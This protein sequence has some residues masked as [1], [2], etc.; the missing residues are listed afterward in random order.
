M[1]IYGTYFFV[2]KRVCCFG[3]LTFRMP[4][5]QLNR[6]RGKLVTT[7]GRRDLSFYSANAATSLVLVFISSKAGAAGNQRPLQRLAGKH[8]VVFFVPNASS[9][10]KLTAVQ[11]RLGELDAGNQKPNRVC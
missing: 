11:V 2:S 3:N 10:H 1:G 9:D 8:G 6:L 7:L 5:L 4:S